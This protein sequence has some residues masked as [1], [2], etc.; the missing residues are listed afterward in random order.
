MNFYDKFQGN[1]FIYKISLSLVFATITETFS[2]KS[3]IVTINS[4]KFD[5][6]LHRSWKC[7]LVEESTDFWLF[8]G[9]FDNEIRHP[10]LGIIR[11]GTQSFEY[12]WKNNWFNIFRF[13]EPEGDFKFYYCNINLPPKFENNVLDYIDLDLD[14]LVWHD[15]SF[16]ILDQ[17][18]FKENSKRFKYPDPVISKV[19]KSLK[20]LLKMIKLKEFPFNF[21]E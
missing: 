13:H 8:V 5:N 4:R 16:E 21:N 15:F 6:S 19:K 14:I 18:E 10:N 9:Q 20:E 2:L 7:Q 11:K 17:D 3:T 1:V 12:Y